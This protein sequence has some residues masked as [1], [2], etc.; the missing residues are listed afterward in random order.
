MEVASETVGTA[1]KLVD[2]GK[3]INALKDG[4]RVSRLG[5]NG[6]GLFVF[7]QVPS[8]VPESIVPKMTSLPESVK[9]VLISRGG[10]LKYS[11][12]MAIINTNNEVNGWVASV[13][14][15][16]SEDWIILD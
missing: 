13:S 15:T 10:D 2:F 1:T 5:W 6:K 7:M 16:L 11:N 14:D 12:Q 3:A 8:L 4:K 9:N